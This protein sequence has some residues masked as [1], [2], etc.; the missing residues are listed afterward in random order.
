MELAYRAPDMALPIAGD[1]RALRQM[2]LALLSNAIKYTPP[3][4]KM[5]L[6]MTLEPGTVAITIADTGVGIAADRLARVTRAAQPIEDPLDTR[7]RGAG[8][9]LAL[10]RLI[11]E[12]LGGTLVLQSA[13]GKGTRV[14]VRLPQAAPTTPLED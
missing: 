10:A 8:I 7:Y 6:G 11:A 2:V 1:R 14:T 12:R 5:A 9:S 4:G 13:L 3:G